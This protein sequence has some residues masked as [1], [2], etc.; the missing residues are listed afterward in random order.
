M[1]KVI[2]QKFQN[3]GFPGYRYILTLIL[4]QI[5]NGKVLHLYYKGLY[6]SSAFSSHGAYKKN[7]LNLERA[8]YRLYVWKGKT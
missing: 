4:S 5:S 1:S 2:G 7:V 3:L 6:L 8:L